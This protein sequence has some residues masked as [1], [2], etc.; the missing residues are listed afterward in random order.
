MLVAMSVS[1][2]VN[3]TWITSV[4]RGARP[5]CV[6]STNI[7][8]WEDRSCGRRAGVNIMRKILKK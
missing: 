8:S 3:S 5:A 2:Q 4:V 6:Q 7:T 1:Q